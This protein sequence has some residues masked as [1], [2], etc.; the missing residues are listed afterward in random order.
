MKGK[1]KMKTKLTMVSV[2]MNGRSRTAFV[3][4]VVNPASSKVR[5]PDYNELFRLLGWENIPAG[6]TFTVG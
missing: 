2:Y 4:L 6:T 3:N 5:V 1:G